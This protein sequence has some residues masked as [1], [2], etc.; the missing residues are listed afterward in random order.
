MIE[1]ESVEQFD[2]YLRSHG[3]LR[4]VAIQGLDLR[5]R[6]DALLGVDVFC[7]FFLGCTLEP[8]ALAAL[9]SGGACVFPR[10]EDL[11][12]RAFRPTLYTAAELYEGYVPGDAD[13]Y[14]STVDGTAYR[15]HR[16]VVESMNV[17]ATLAQRIHD[18]A[19][20]DALHATLQKVGTGSVVAVMGGHG[21]A[22]TDDAYRSAVEL[23]WL[24]AENGFYVA[25]GGGP[26][27]MEAANL[28][29]YLSGHP[30]EALDEA[31]DI[32]A[33]APSYK[34][35]GP[36][37]DTGFAVRERFPRPSD[38]SVSL[39]VP[40]WHYGHEPPNVFGTEIAKYFSNSI[41][42]DGLLAIALGGV[43]FAPGSAGTIQEIF[44][45][46][47]QNHYKSFGIASPMVF[48]DTDYWTETKPVYPVIKK[49][50]SDREYGAL[51]DA[52]DEVADVVDYI[53]AFAESSP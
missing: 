38:R 31:L 18:H 40:T 50:S 43:V 25:T 46:A 6:T 28:G 51:V 11:P 48:L 34:T 7:A 3:D 45:D 24:L 39:G 15:W 20:D 41:R 14:A 52:F 44:Q 42:E 26:G 1:I 17:V 16:E 10:F 5:E 29:A 27:A 23:G 33:T 53:K 37:L 49:L 2:E 32:L 9:Q 12:V 13:S 35:M 30:G 8:E 19:I 21:L 47:A 4:D 36:W 22:R